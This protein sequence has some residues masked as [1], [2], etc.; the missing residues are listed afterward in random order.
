MKE[1]LSD[2]YIKHIHKQDLPLHLQIGLP[3]AQSANIN[4][5]YW[6][7]ESK[8]A[9]TVD[10]EA[11]KRMG[12]PVGNHDEKKREAMQMEINEVFRGKGIEKEELSRYNARQAFQKLKIGEVASK[13]AFSKAEWTNERAPS[14]PNVYTDGSM[15][16][17]RYTMYALAG[18]GI[19]WPGRKLGNHPLSQREIEMAWEE[20]E[21]DGVKLST[22]IAGYGGSS[23]RAEIAGVLVALAATGGVHIATDSQAVV[24]KGTYLI[25]LAKEGKKTDESF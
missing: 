3:G 17:P 11:R 9:K 2:T 22:A 21:T 18:A 10:P 15:R 24:Q 4:G 8:D 19:W 13:D 14:E 12:L 23:T 7:L 6:G 16:H 25:D 5:T 20:Q 1:Q